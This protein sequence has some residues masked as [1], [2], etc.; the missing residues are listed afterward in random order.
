MITEQLGTALRRA[1]RLV[2]PHGPSAPSDADLLQR[3]RAGADEAAFARLV[4]RHGRLVLGVCRQVLHHEQDAEDA[5]Q[6]TFLVLARKASA[7][8]KGSAVASWLYGVAYRVAMK[9]KTEA[10]RRRN[11]EQRAESPPRAAASLDVAWRELQAVLH[12]ELNGLPEKFRSPFVLCCLEGK[13]KAE[14]AEQLGWKEGTVS[15]R[16]AQARKQMRERL[17]RRGL[18]LAAALGAASLA[19]G[20]ASAGL[21]GQTARAAALFRTGQSLTAAGLSAR[22]A[23]LAQG[24]LDTMFPTALRPTTALLVALGVLALG[25]AAPAWG[26]VAGAVAPPGRPAEASPCTGRSTANTARRAS[27]CSGK[28]RRYSS[29]SGRSPCRSRSRNSP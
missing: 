18:T 29:G 9:A 3:F 28:R 4:K 6:A 1:R 7:I 19:R 25:P 17:T 14:A 8:R 20:A 5:F 24:V 15:G 10:A 11:R 27:A 13:S 22:A 21:V 12:E 23:A 2:D 26:V 16:L